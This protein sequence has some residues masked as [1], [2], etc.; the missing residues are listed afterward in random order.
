M[1]FSASMLSTWGNCSLQGKFKYIDRLP[2]QTGSSAH[3]GSCVHAACELLHKGGTVD[4]AV[5]VFLKEYNSLIPDY[6]NRRTNYE[7]LRVKGLDMVQGYAEFLEWKTDSRYIL[8]EHPFMVDMGEH[9]LSGIVDYV[10]VPKGET[11]ITVG[12]LKAGYKPN[13]DQLHLALQFTVYD[14]ASRQKQFWTGH[15]SNLEKYP[16]V[17]HGE[18]L[19]EMFKDFDRKLIWFDLKDMKEIDVGARTDRDYGRLY[20]CMEQI[21]RAIQLEVFVPTVNDTSCLWCDFKKE[22]P[23]YWEVDEVDEV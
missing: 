21:D 16:P 6:Y 23:V 14:W 7:N 17:P 5:D 22:C 13:M 2:T 11:Y 12:D 1:R 8:A 20:R 9:T 18:E 15:P 19:Y 3:F 4:Q 10:E